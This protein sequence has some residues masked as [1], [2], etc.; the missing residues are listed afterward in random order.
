MTAKGLDLH[1]AIKRVICVFCDMYLEEKCKGEKERIV[2]CVTALRN[3]HLE[4]MAEKAKKGRF[5]STPLCQPYDKRMEI[6]D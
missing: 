4:R 5:L 1:T 3:S 6:D 2:Q